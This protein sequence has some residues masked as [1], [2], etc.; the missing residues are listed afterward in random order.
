MD[1][2]TGTWRPLRAELDGELAPKEALDAM[3]L[4]LSEANYRVKFGRD[5][6]DQGAL[7]ANHEGNLWQLTLSGQKGVNAGRV[8]PAIAQ[9]RGDR[10]RICFGLNGQRPADFTGGPNSG[11]Y[12]VNYRRDATA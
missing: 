10:I 4:I 6:S 9:I 5:V 3:Q 8:I 11:C 2:L 7:V 12:L 1:T